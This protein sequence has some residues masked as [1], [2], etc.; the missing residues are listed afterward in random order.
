MR[1][2]SD[3]DRTASLMTPAKLAQLKVQ[4][5][6]VTPA[7]Y[8]DQL[9]ADAG[10]GH[11]R[12][13]IDL[14]QQLEAQLRDREY[15]GVAGAARALHDALAEV[16]FSLVQPRG[17][18]ARATGK[19]K[20]AVAG[21]RAQHQR[22]KHAGEDFAEH[23]DAVRKRQQSDPAIDRMLLEVEVEI[24]ALEKIMDQGARWLQ[25]M[26]NQLKARQA[27]GGDAAAQAQ[28]REDTARCE[29]LVARLKQ[30]RA[31]SA[32]AQQVVEQFRGAATRRASFCASLQQVLDEPAKAWR[33]RAAKV[34]EQAAETGSAA[35][36]IEEAREALQELQSALQRAMQDAGAVQA[37]EQALADATAALG[38]PLQA[39]A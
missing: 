3:D 11:I 35:Q 31:A 22:V 21:F 8:L 20:E 28:M 34:A 25:D 10:S 15:R 12:R 32:A 7:A 37:Q 39:A 33:H 19:G 13:L 17:W 2:D 9:A 4:P 24:R 5:K 36:G 38:E 6:P 27:Q 1:D 26:R 16:D 23:V 18:L 14:R 30:L 29:L